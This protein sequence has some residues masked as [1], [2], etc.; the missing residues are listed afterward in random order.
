MPL[1]NQIVALEKGLKARTTRAVTDIYHGLKKAP[2]YTGISRVYRPKD[3]DGEQLPQESTRVQ[4]TVEE[5]LARARDLVG[6]LLDVVATKEYG[7]TVAR[8]DVT[9][10]G[11]VLLLD[12]PVPFLLALEKQLVDW[13]TMV[14][15]LPVLDPSEVWEYDEDNKIFRTQATETHRTRKIPRVLLKAPATERHPAQT[16]VYNEDVVVGYWSTTKLSG[17]VPRARRDALVERADKLIDAVKA[18]REQAN[19][20]EVDHRKVA[21]PLLTYLLDA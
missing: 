11:Q 5:D 18:A 15:A 13:R 12:A 4:L 3:E 6:N 20:A 1:L 9:V 14:Q 21:E 7:N 8:A 10:N 2:L 19:S 16:E 17:A